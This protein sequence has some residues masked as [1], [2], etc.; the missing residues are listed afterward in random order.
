MARWIVTRCLLLPLL[1]STAV[2]TAAKQ[3]AIQTPSGR[4]EVF[5]PGVS[6]KD[7]SNRLVQRLLPQGFHV[8]RM[9]D[10]Q[11]VFGRRDERV[12]VQMLAGSAMNQY[13]EDRFLFTFA[14][15][16]GGTRVFVREEIVSN[17][18]SAFEN[19]TPLDSKKNYLALQQLLE[20]M[21]EGLLA[22]KKASE[23]PA[24]PETAVPASPQVA[25]EAAG[26]EPAAQAESS[27]VLIDSVPTGAEVFLNGAFVGTTPYSLTS[28]V[29]GEYVVEIKRTGFADWQRKVT[30]LQGSRT[31]FKAE[32]T[33]KP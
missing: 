24:S 3:P 12:L 28:P 33:P 9:D 17:P 15:E 11:A 20:Q 26:V 31:Q 6:S 7:V 1:V 5:V 27:S 18:G 25:A 14:P 19:P 21:R 4:P 23:P 10:Y 8:V 16:A 29:P 32:L 22:A 13:P 30:I 2:M